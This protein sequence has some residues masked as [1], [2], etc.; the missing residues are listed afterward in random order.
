M[1]RGGSGQEWI[2][3]PGKDGGKASDYG[4]LTLNGISLRTSFPSLSC[5]FLQFCI[6]LDGF[7]IILMCR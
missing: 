1:G 7:R 3:E 4:N 2:G 6:S 5:K